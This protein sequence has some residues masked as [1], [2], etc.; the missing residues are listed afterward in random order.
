MTFVFQ[1]NDPFVKSVEIVF[2]ILNFVL[3]GE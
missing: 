1:L 3:N 2:Q